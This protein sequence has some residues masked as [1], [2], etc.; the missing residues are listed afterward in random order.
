MHEEP[1]TTTGVA[2]FESGTMP[3][4]Q[5]RSHPALQGDALA[6]TLAALVSVPSVNPGTSER[7][8]GD[9]VAQLLHGTGCELTFVESMPGRPSLAAVLTGT[10]VDGPRLVLNGHMD[11]VP[12]DD[13]R[14]WTI[15]PFAGKVDDGRVWGR[16]AADMKGGLTTQI[17]VA[18]VLAGVRPRLRGTLV[19]HFAAGEERGEPGTLSLL[20]R[21]FTGDWGITTEPT[22]LDVAV[23]QRGVAWFKVL[24]GGRSAHAACADN[25]VNTIERVG[26]VTEALRRYDQRIRVRTHPLLGPS[27]C[28]VTMVRAGVEQNA[29]P[30]ICELVVDRRMIPGD[31]VETTRAEIGAVLREVAALDPEAR[32]ELEPYL[33]PFPPAEV[34]EDAA[35]VQRAIRTVGAVRGEQPAV[36]G[37]PYG[38]DVRN[39]VN[40]AGMTA[41]TFGAGDI[42]NCHVPNEYMAIQQLQSAS[43]AVCKLAVDL[44]S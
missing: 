42:E 5:L 12:I 15:D 32:Y 37:T 25:G 40:D 43:V 22:S 20:E 44:L 24:I 28:A 10:A 31:S 4:Q 26:R 41:I 19:L 34:P 13:D 33:N 17:A 9:R 23:A 38:S 11:T 1:M 21:G 7:A 27:R 8:M 30:D 3:L 6:E 14:L 2:E 16:G 18:K 29:V 36:I 39:L 35:F